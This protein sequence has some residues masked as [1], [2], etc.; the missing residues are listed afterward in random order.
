M[1]EMAKEMARP[2]RRLRKLSTH[3]AGGPCAQSEA[4][5]ESLTLEQSLTDAE[6][7]TCIVRPPGRRP[8]LPAWSPRVGSWPA[9]R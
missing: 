9:E 1:A 8:R 3:L 5:A 7:D 2:A 6:R 4:V